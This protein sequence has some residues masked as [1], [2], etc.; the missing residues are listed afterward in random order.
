MCG[1]GQFCRSHDEALRLLHGSRG[2]V[3]DSALY[4]TAYGLDGMK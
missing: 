4:E 3:S 1:T 2:V